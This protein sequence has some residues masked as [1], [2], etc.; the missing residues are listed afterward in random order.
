MA[1]GHIVY[2]GVARDSPLYFESMG[3]KAGRFANP[4]DSF[5]KLLA[6]NYPKEQEDEDKLEMLVS[7]YKNYEAKVR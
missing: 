4:A 6:I 5:M 1:D 2:Q 3:F 7:T